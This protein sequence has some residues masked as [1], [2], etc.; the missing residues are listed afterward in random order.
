MHMVPICLIPVPLPL[1]N[2]TILM[3]GVCYPYEGL[4]LLSCN[5]HRDTHGHH[6]SPSGQLAERR[7]WHSG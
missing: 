6:L 3:Y 4:S 1:L 7:T 2:S 5:G